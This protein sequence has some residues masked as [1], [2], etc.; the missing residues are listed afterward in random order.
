MAQALADGVPHASLASLVVG[1]PWG[2]Q[3][4]AQWTGAS[5]DLVVR[6]D[7]PWLMEV[8]R[9]VSVALSTPS[10]EVTARALPWPDVLQRRAQRA[11]TLMIDFARPAGPGPLGALLGLAAADDPA[12]AIALARHP[13]RRDLAPRAVTRTMRVGVVGEVRLQGGRAPDVVLPGSPWG[14]GLDW[15]GA[16][17][18]R[19]G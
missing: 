9:A 17:R 8:A 15:A 19:R 3:A 2:Q 18:A 1:P 6:D 13:P 10:H 14:Y 4:S 16:F 5:C 12:S 7:A 11:F